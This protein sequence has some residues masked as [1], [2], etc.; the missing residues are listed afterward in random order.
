[1]SFIYH[2]VPN[3]LQGDTLYPLNSLR[4]IYPEVY[5]REI[6][7]YH[8]REH[9]S[10]Q[11]IPLFDNCLWNDVLFFTAVSPAQLYEERRKAGWP[12]VQPQKFFKIDPRNLD[13]TTLGVFLFQPQ[14]DPKNLVD[15]NFAN[16][17]Y[18]DSPAYSKIPDETKEY[19]KHEFE[20]G[21]PHI[22]LFWKYIP[23]ILYH[24]SIN[25]SDT[26]VIVV[27]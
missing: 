20:I 8:G 18:E 15:N 12:D 22:K 27:N 4:E 16:Y 26:E 9:V 14:I 17:R 2:R 24:G 3:N 23:H 5:E 7:K 13:Q 1:M 19:Y 25:V 10:E 6:A 11:R 21:K